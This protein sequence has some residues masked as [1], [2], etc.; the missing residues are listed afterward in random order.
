M[1]F[2]AFVL[3]IL[4]LFPAFSVQ[5]V[6]YA[7]LEIDTTARI[8]DTDANYICATLD[9]WPHDKC[10]YDHCPWGLASVMNLV[11]ILTNHRD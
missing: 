1:G 7:G 5:A 10:N 2:L 11:T 4:A 8:A 3:T 6:E 9:W